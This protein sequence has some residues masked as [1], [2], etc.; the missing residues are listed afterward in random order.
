MSGKW[1][2]D[3]Y[4]DTRESSP[5]YGRGRA[6]L[7]PD[8]EPSPSCGRGRAR[9]GRGNQLASRDHLKPGGDKESP[10][11][12]DE[13]PNIKKDVEGT[14]SKKKRPEVQVYVPRHRRMQE[15]TEDNI[16][17]YEQMSKEKSNV[18]REEQNSS[19][20]SSPS[21]LG[22]PSK[23]PKTV[24]Q[25]YIPRPKR[26]QLEEESKQSPVQVAAPNTHTEAAATSSPIDESIIIHDAEDDMKTKRHKHKKHKHR[27]KSRDSGNEKYS[28]N[29]YAN[30]CDEERRNRDRSA[31]TIDSTSR[32]RSHSRDKSKKKKK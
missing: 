17:K 9:P 18:F 2:H 7:N 30:G 22:R 8:R 6:R 25:V 4:S 13:I 31:E 26:Q 15:Q 21:E 11:V 29:D 16:S 19:S 10:Y 12:T 3:G 14:R 20:L 1:G 28:Q 27:S 23:K 5:S 32:H 24:S